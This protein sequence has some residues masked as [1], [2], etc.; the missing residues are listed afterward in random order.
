[1]HDLAGQQVRVPRRFVFLVDGDRATA[2]QERRLTVARRGLDE[3]ILSFSLPTIVCTGNY[4]RQT[5]HT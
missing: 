5:K 4:H 1:M 2:K 3:G